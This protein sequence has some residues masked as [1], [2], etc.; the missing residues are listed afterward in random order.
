MSERPEIQLIANL[1]VH[2]HDGR[3][4]LARYDPTGEIDAPDAE[5]RWWLPAHELDNYQH[6]DEAATIAIDEIGSLDVESIELARVQSFR[7]RRGWHLSFDYRVVA[8]GEP[9]GDIRADWFERADLPATMHG[10][11]ER[12]TIDAVLD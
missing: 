3:V 5:V 6:P 10:N 2:D 8:S 1:V 7:G 9:D 11:W 12:D 4:L